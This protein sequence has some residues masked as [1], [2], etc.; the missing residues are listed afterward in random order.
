[1]D[2]GRATSAP[3]ENSARLWLSGFGDWTAAARK[4]TTKEETELS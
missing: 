4:R 3:D 2:A 1:M